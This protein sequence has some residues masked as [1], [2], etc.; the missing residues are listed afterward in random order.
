MIKAFDFWNGLCKSKRPWSKRYENT[1][2][3]IEEP[4]TVAKLHFFSFVAGLL[5]PFLKVFQGN[6][7]MVPFLCNNIRSIYIS[8]LELIVNAKVLENIESHD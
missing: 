2:K 1:R 4:L 3:G 7:P 5:Q 8:L 6:G